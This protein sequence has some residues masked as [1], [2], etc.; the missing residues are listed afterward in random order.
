L[1]FYLL[2]GNLNINLG[3]STVP[4]PPFFALKEHALVLF[5]MS[6]ERCVQ[7]KL[8]GCERKLEKNFI[9]WN[10]ITGVVEIIDHADIKGK[11]AVGR[12]SCRWED[13]VK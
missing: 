12:P 7:A 1:F 9:I 8:G 5:E 11:T 3:I 10:C 2:S 13:I 6:S 4:P